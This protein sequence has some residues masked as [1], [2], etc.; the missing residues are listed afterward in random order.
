MA[1]ITKAQYL[2]TIPKV[3]ELLAAADIR[4][5]LATHPREVVVDGI[6]AA[7]E[8][9]RRTILE[10]DNLEGLPEGMVRLPR[11]VELVRQEITTRSTPRLRRAINATGI[12]IHTN[13][14]R[15]PLGTHVMAHMIDVA[16]GYSNL[17][18]DL[19]TGARG[20]R[21]EHVEELLCRLSGAEASLVVNNN[22][23][24]VLLALNTLAAGRDVIVSRGELVE[25]GGG[26]RVPEVMARSG[27]VLHEVG[28]TNRTHRYDYERAVGPSTAMILK[29]HTSNYQVV[30][31]TAE[32][33]VEELVELGRRHDLPVMHDLGSGC[34]IDLSAYGLR[35]EPTVQDAVKAGADV[36]TFSGDKL[37]GGPQTGIIL[38]RRPIV[39]R[40]KINP[41]NRALR[42]DKLTLAALERTLL[43]YLDEEEAIREIPTLRMITASATSLRRKASR[44]LRLLRRHEPPAEISIVRGVSRVGG[45][46]LPIQ[47]LPTWTV[48]IAPHHGSVEALEEALR[49]GSPPI[50]ARIA[51]DH[52]IL[53]VRTIQN[54]EFAL[55]ATGVST[56]L[57]AMHG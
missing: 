1:E 4:E 43:Y 25:I 8:G 55:V 39:D 26:F 44:L 48:A 57:L 51:D 6:R 21:Y 42:I 3:D 40:I 18:Y 37:L 49:H 52:L 22:A 7:L 27:A 32:V 31:F 47:E 45:G 20:S 9:V 19:D 30:G 23:G 10:T 12:I 46:A 34:F 17:E 50:V 16:R 35:R 24:A 11:L 29:V 53:D 14:G 5:L 36:I 28:T 15:S 38:G 2:R 33:S 41:L 13:L 56:S 54:D